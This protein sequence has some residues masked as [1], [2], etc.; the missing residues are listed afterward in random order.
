MTTDEKIDYNERKALQYGWTPEWFDCTAF[1][2]ELIDAIYA[3]QREHGL[4]ADGMCGPTTFRIKWTE[5]DQEEESLQKVEQDDSTKYIVYN[6]QQFQIFWDKVVLWSQEGGQE[7]SQGNYSS[8]AGEPARQPRF[9]VSHWDVCLSSASCYRVLEQR[10]ISVHFGIDNDGTIY[11]W[12]DMQHAAWHAG[13]RAWNHS[14]VGVEVSDAYYPDKYQSWYVKNGFGE[15]PIISGATCHGKP[16]APFM[17]FYDVQ[18]EALAALW[19]AVSYACKIPLELPQ[20]VA[21]VDPTCAAN[22]FDG[23][24]NHYHLTTRKIDCSGLDN[25]AI[26]ERAK[27]LR[28]KRG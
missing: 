12:L 26:L 6:T 20:T 13:G 18:L 19:E 27:Q 17:G 1:D 11:Q 21:A 15:R 10:G 3:F 23:F 5:R 14:S 25:P 7:A 16:L 8:Y 9:F 4:S 24:C 28:L 2:A 22:E